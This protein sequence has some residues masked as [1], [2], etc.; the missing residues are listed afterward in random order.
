MV[1]PRLTVE[2]SP[3]LDAPV[4]GTARQVDDGYCL[5]FG[6]D[7]N[8]SAKVAKNGADVARVDAACQ[9]GRWHTVVGERGGDVLGLSVDGREVLKWRDYVPVLGQRV[10]LYCWGDGLRVRR[11]RVFTRG[12]PVTVSCLE[13]PNAFYNEGLIEK[14]QREYLRIAESHPGRAEGLEAVFLAGKCCVDLAGKDGI[15]PAERRRLLG[16]AA[17]YFDRLEQGCLAPLGCLGKSLIHELAGDAEAEAG[18]LTRAYQ[19][20]GGY[21]ALHVVGE[22]LWQRATGLVGDPRSQLFVLP[23]ARHHPDGLLS[24]NSIKVLGAIPDIA[25]AVDALTAAIERFRDPPWLC[26]VALNTLGQLL[27]RAG[28]DKQSLAAHE[29]VLREYPDERP[30]CAEALWGIGAVH[31]DYGQTTEAVSAF[32]RVLAEY[33]D[34]RFWCAV[35]LEHIG[36]AHIGSGQYDAALDVF[37]RVL[38][39]YP[40]QSE[41]CATSLGIMGSTLAWRGEHESAWAT[42]QRLQREL[43]SIPQYAAGALL[44]MARVQQGRGRNDQAWDLY[45]RAARDFPGAPEQR[46]AALLGMSDIC[47][48][49]GDYDRVLSLCEEAIEVCEGHS[50]RN[51]PGRRHAVFYFMCIVHVLRRDRASVRQ[52]LERYVRM[53][54]MTWPLRGARDPHDAEAEG[55]CQGARRKYYLFLLAAGAFACGDDETAIRRLRE[56]LEGFGQYSLDPGF[57]NAKLLLAAVTRE[58]KDG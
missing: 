23:A 37:E 32:R 15:D 55:H 7:Y 33:P 48:Q 17:G 38:T 57:L 11:F 54:G 9:P 45:E 49:R 51:W 36:A 30:H 43:G 10:G 16:E 27:A 24:G 47:I 8:T 58:G 18:E 14:A 1:A 52:H 20:Y 42:F 2:I 5:Q 13:V 46:A 56:C 41:V 34:Q 53:C 22:R 44:G 6:A 19:D 29:K 21:D 50:G 35:A 4:P 26:A 25:V 28:Q 39:E 40:E 31:R 12:V 3:L